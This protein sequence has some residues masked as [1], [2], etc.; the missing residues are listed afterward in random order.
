[1]SGRWPLAA[2]RLLTAD[3]LRNY[4]CQQFM[5]PGGC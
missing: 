4:A 2:G 3:W 5:M 1:M